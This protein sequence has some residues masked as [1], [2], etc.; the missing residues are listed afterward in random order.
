MR[1]AAHGPL[2][3]AAQ[4]A[5]HP[6]PCNRARQ[7]I[8]CNRDLVHLC[9]CCGAARR[10]ASP[11][12]E[13]STCDAGLE[14]DARRGDVGARVE[15]GSLWGGSGR[16]QGWRGACVSLC[17]PR[18]TEGQGLSRSGADPRLPRAI[19]RNVQIPGDDARIGYYLP[20]DVETAVAYETK[21]LSMPQNVPLL[22]VEN[23]TV[24]SHSRCHRD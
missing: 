17:A 9:G 18:L 16:G 6:G 22:P 4:C 13:A 24:R 2:L 1:P 7:G 5:S 3:T 23:D 10:P 11:H 20:T 15:P 14:R 19:F 8:S 12:E 21:R